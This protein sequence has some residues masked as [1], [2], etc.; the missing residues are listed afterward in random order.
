LSHRN[1]FVYCLDSFLNC[2]SSHFEM[3]KYDVTDPTF[4]TRG[5][6]AVGFLCTLAVR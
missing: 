6:Y 4:L 1:V 5:M 2:T 3:Y